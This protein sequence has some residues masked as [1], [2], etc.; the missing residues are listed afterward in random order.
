MISYGQNALRKKQESQHAKDLMALNLRKI[1]RSYLMPR[2]GRGR[3]SYNHKHQDKRSSPPP[4]KRNKRKIYLRFNA[5][6]ARNTVIMPVVV[7]VQS[8]GSMKLQLLM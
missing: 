8:K 3:K 5:T 1:K 6:G 7:K 4:I 2:K